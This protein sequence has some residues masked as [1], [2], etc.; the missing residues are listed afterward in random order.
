MQL[1]T[2]I[3]PIPYNIL[4]LLVLCAVRLKGFV[5]LSLTTKGKL[6]WSVARSDGELK[7]MKEA[8]DLAQV[9]AQQG[10]PEVAELIAYCRSA[11]RSVRPNYDTVREMLTRLQARKVRKEF[12]VE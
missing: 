7:H 1:L 5:L 8:C 12:C 6:P 3:V 10:C 9:C 4:Y 11:N 2:L